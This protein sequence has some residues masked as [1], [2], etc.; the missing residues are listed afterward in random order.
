M[1]LALFRYLV[2]GSFL[3]FKCVADEDVKILCEEA[4]IFSLPSSTSEITQ[5]VV[6]IADIQEVSLA[7]N[8]FVNIHAHIANR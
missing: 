2:V 8:K 4:R 7:T 5:E 1:A 3:N 6:G